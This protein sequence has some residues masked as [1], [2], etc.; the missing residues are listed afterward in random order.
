MKSIERIL[1]VS[2]TGIGNMI[3]YTPVLRTLKKWYPLSQ[4]TLLCGSREAPRLKA[5]APRMGL[6]PK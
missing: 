6:T 1:A 3:L 2:T 5:N 4:T